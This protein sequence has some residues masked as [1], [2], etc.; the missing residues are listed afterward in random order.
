MNA[1]CQLI[2]T[3]T[4]YIQLKLDVISARL[5]TCYLCTQIFGILSTGITSST[6]QVF[7]VLQR[8]TFKFCTSK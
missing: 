3:G 7:Y 4:S 8:K 2:T 6:N 5:I 1:W